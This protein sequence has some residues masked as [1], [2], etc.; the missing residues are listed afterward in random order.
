MPMTT[1]GIKDTG[2]LIADEIAA[3]IVLA[4]DQE[5]SSVPAVVQAALD[6]GSFE[7]KV[8]DKSPEIPEEYRDISFAQECL[9]AKGIGDMHCS[10]FAGNASTLV[11]PGNEK[12][13]PRIWEYEDDYIAYIPAKAPSLFEAAYNSPD[14]LIQEFRARL[15]GILPKDFDL[16]PYIAEIDGTFVS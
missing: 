4:S 7:Q 15:E 13:T 3:Y 16:R 12:M 2:L 11:L 9:E 14:E 10:E 1:Y 8:L 6:D 5:N